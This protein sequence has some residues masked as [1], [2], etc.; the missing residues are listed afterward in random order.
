M[1]A[2][3]AL[4]ATVLST[5]A[6]TG[7]G[8]NIPECNVLGFGTTRS[9]GGVCIQAQLLAT[10]D[11]PAFLVPQAMLDRYYD[12]YRRAVAAEPFV[13]RGIAFS[14]HFIGAMR[15]SNRQIGEAWYAKKLHTGIEDFDYL[16]SQ[17]AT[18]IETAPQSLSE[19][20]FSMQFEV[21]RLY[22]P[23]HLA[24]LLP[25]TIAEPPPIDLAGTSWPIATLTWPAGAPVEGADDLT[26]TIDSEFSF[27]DCFTGCAKHYLRAV[28]SPTEVVV[29]DMGGFAIP[30]ELPDEYQL[31]STTIPWPGPLPPR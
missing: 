27:T 18:K 17:I 5:T 10:R 24:A 8:D 30:P 31:R 25:A 4:F 9:G 23:K 6:C 26:A 7:V 19:S 2:W 12:R 21:K 16:F 14:T 11:S 22:S 20:V 28:V 13:M 29:Y 3:L 15:T 1:T